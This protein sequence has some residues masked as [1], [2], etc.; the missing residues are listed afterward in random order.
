MKLKQTKYVTCASTEFGMQANGDA[1]CLYCGNV[2]ETRKAYVIN[3]DIIDVNTG[4]LKNFLNI[5]GIVQ[6]QSLTHGWH[7]QGLNSFHNQSALQNTEKD[8]GSWFGSLFGGIF[9]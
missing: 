6:T 8:S 7:Y 5:G 2:Y 4:A 1:K 9:G 3:P